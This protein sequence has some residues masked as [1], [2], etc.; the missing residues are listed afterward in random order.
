M[1]SEKRI[2]H[3]ECEARVIYSHSCTPID[4]YYCYYTLM[5]QTENLKRRRQQ[6][7]QQPKM[8]NT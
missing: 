4:T 7:Q 3:E 1:R 6:R 2:I 8:P 5:C